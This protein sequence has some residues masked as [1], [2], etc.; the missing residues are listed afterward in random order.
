MDCSFVAGDY[1]APGPSGKALP[2]RNQLGALMIWLTLDESSAAL[3]CAPPYLA[4]VGNTPMG[5]DP[6]SLQLTAEPASRPLARLSF[7]TENSR[8]RH[9]YSHLRRYTVLSRRHLFLGLFLISLAAAALRFNRSTS[10]DEW[11]PITP[12]EL[13]MTSEPKAPGAPA[14]TLYRQV[15]RDDSQALRPHE[16]SYVRKKIFTEEGRKN[17]DVEIPVIKGEWDIHSIRARTVR[18]D[19]SVIDF[20][21]KVYEK[22]IVKARGIKFLAKTFTLSDVQPGSII[23]YHYMTDF[24]E[25]YVFNSHWELNDELFTKRAKFTLKPYGP[26]ALQWSWPNG[27]PE[28]AKPPVDEHSLIHMEVQDIPAF[29]VEDDMPPEE[30]VKF[31]V[32]FIYSED[33]FEKDPEKFWMKRGKKMDEGAENFLNKRKAMEQAVAQIVSPSDSPEVKLRKLYEKTQSIRNTSYEMEKTEQEQKRAKEK[34]VENVE[35]IWKRGYADEFQINWLF[36]GLARGAGF[37]ASAVRTSRRDDRFFQK[38]M[39]NARDLGTNAVLVKLDGKD[40][41][42]DPGAAYTPFGMLP[43]SVAGVDGL[44]LD[45]DGGTWVTTPNPDSSAS[46]IIRK[47]DLSMTSEGSLQGKLTVTFTGLEAVWRRVRERHEDEA[48]RKKFLEDYVKE[49]VPAGIEVD[50]TNKPDWSSSA[51]ALLAEYSLK[52][53]GWVSGAGRRA[54]MPVGLFCESEKHMF[55]HSTRVHPIYFQYRYEKS[56]DVRVELPLGW[57][58][59][60]LP[61]PVNNDAKLLVYTMKVENDKGTLHLERHLKCSLTI[62]EQKYYGNL[63]NFYQSVRSADEQQ[64]VLQPMGASSGN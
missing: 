61:Q 10:A 8:L 51:P 3:Y 40:M 63:R 19:G 39:M 28:G 25:G 37:D 36:L 20:D 45:K 57:Q 38:N 21:G 41:Y 58:V 59:G 30:A 12:E 44:K 56:D 42:L 24:A 33:G 2:G 35:E 9:F 43:W 22:E 50:L 64:I 13:K 5:R 1:A 26:W 4:Q 48:H 47:A 34:V 62:L 60:S 23:E 18:P 32:D 15:D 16:Y 54:L 17:A 49:I 29:Q 7:S 6:S 52:I 55:E 14:I 53:P 11:L 31:I 46:Q 27:L